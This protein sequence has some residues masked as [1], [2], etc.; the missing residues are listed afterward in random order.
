MET[1]TDQ[2]APVYT[3]DLM[4]SASL[5]FLHAWENGKPVTYG[6][7]NHVDQNNSRYV[8][9]VT[10]TEPTLTR[11]LFVR[12]ADDIVEKFTTPGEHYFISY[13]GVDYCRDGFMV[14]ASVYKKL[15]AN[16]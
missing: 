12:L 16:G 15:N 14:K 7:G 11:E 10:R 4:H 6:T 13:V 1:V 3:L 9:E 8:G 2:N 5:G